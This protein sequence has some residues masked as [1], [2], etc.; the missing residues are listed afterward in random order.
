M[1]LFLALVI[2][3]LLFN[4]Y[5]VPSD[6]MEPALLPG[7]FILAEKFTYGSRI[8]T[9]LRFDSDNDPPMIHVPGLR[10]ER[11]NDVIVFNFPY[12]NGWDTIRLNLEKTLVKRCVGLPGDSISI[13][14]GYYRIAGIDDPVGY[15]MG[16]RLLASNKGKLDPD[17]MQTFPYDSMIPWNIRNFGPLFVPAV[18]SIIALTPTNYILYRKMMI[19]E[20]NAMIRNIDSA[21]Y[22]DDKLTTHYTFRSNWYFVAGDKV[23]NSEDSRY[24]GLIP[25]SYIIGRALIIMTSKDPFSGKR[26]WNRMLKKIA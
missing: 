4:F 17:F 2:R 9:R 20:T 21:V 22:I 26:R 25:E 13:V 6:S 16:Q 7:D 12:R 14:N 18:G 24:F 10:S 23:I 11:R 15:R 3:V 1:S 19:Y 8:F 5:L